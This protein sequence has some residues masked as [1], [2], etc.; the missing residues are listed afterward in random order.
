MPQVRF[1]RVDRFENRPG[2]AV[3]QLRVAGIALGA[4][5]RRLL[6]RR[7]AGGGGADRLFLPAADQPLTDG[8]G[9]PSYSAGTAERWASAFSR[10]TASYKRLLSVPSGMPMIAAASRYL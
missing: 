7:R 3:R 8:R 5:R 6:D 2:R 4:L 1:A 9:E 10:C